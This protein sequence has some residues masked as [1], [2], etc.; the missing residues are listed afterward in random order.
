MSRK[1][2]TK[3]TKPKKDSPTEPPYS[4]TEDGASSRP[5]RSKLTKCSSDFSI[6]KKQT[7]SRAKSQAQ[8]RMQRIFEKLLGEEK[9]L[10]LET[11]Y[12]IEVFEYMRSR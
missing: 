12:L 1:N 10:H 2:T 3:T 4:D 11:A 7:V 6:S 5:V 9:M 8:Q